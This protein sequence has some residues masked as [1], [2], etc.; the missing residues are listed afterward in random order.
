MKHLAGQKNQT[1]KDSS[2]VVATPTHAPA[3][4]G[5]LLRYYDA[6]S[7][8][9]GPMRWWPANTPFEVIVGAILTQS[10]AWGNVELAIANLHSAQLLTPSAMLRVRTSR[11]ATLIRPSGYFRQ[12]AKK[13]KAFVRFLQTGYKGS[14]ARMFQTPTAELREKLLEVHGIGPET[15]DSILLYGGNH[16]I[17]VVDA[18][19]HRILGRHGIT[20][21][22]AAYE[23]VRGLIEDSIPRQAELFNEFHAL[24]VNTGKNW[25]R[26]SAPRCEE[27]PLRPLLPANSP[28]AVFNGF[29]QAKTSVSGSLA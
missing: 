12:K 17:F 25:C 5:E 10:T 8:A 23:K 16:P 26:K 3:H 27:C 14:L 29:V 7:A 28:F 24:I 13:L 11:L 19:T 15:A 4:S 9:L 18:Y 22:K 2:Q 6:M 1:A 21:G 20:D